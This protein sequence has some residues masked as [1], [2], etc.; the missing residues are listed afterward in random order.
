M[1]RYAKKVAGNVKLNFEELMMVL[2]QIE[3]CMNYR[4]LIPL[5]DAK[6]NLEVLIPGHFF[7]GRPLEALLISPTQILLY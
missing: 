2:A 6:D 4:P 5:A 1:K 7:I 3:A